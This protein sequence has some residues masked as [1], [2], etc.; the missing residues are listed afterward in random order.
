MASENNKRLQRAFAP[1]LKACGF[2]KDGATWRKRF[3][4]S[5]AVFRDR[6]RCLELLDIDRPIP[7]AQRLADLSIAASDA[8]VPWLRTMAFPARARATISAEPAD[9]LSVTRETRKYLGL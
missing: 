2:K 6:N 8:A 7:E 5:V 4:Q 1:L 3:P 9:S